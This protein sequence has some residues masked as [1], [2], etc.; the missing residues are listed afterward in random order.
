[1][2]TN[3]GAADLAKRGDRLPQ[4]SARATTTKRST[5][6]SRR[7][8]ATGSTPIVPFSP[9]PEEVIGRVV[10]KFVL[11]LEAQLADRNVTIE[12]TDEA[13][14]WLAKNGYDEAIGARPLARVIQE[15]IKKP[16]ADEL[17]FGKLKNGGVVRVVV[18]ADDAGSRSSA[19]SIPRARRSRGSSAT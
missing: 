10:D 17:L 4:R 9:L 12:L 2:T 8:S 19:S 13:R 14:A 5:G 3:A 6:C 15:Q 18:T 11:Q 7:S 16:L 1:M